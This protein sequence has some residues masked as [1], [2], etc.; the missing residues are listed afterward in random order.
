MRSFLLTI[1]LLA[2]T[3]C[4]VLSQFRPAT[5]PGDPYTDLI[6][7][8]HMPLYDKLICHK[9][10]GILNS[11]T[12]IIIQNKAYL[13]FGVN[14]VTYDLGNSTYLIQLVHQ[15]IDEDRWWTL[16][17]EWAH[18][19]QFVDGMLEEPVSGPIIWMGMPNDFNKP[20]SERPWELNAEDLANQLWEEH[21][22]FVKKPEGRPR[23]K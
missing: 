10:Y 9:L 20:W 4:D 11:E 21:L 7:D 15:D 19:F 13:P 5:I 12:T 16:L 2:Y 17:H 22:F 14:G 18:I 1:I 23:T 3:N 8:K 6:F